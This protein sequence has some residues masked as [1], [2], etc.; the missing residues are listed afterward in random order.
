MA[1]R[2]FGSLA[3]INIL[4]V[5]QSNINFSF[6]LDEKDVNGAIQ[7]LH[8]DFFHEIDPEVFQPPA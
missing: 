8:E 5:S 7:K 1:R 6:L 3:D 4:A 2:A